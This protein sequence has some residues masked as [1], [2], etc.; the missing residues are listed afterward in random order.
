MFCVSHTV[1][2]MTQSG[3]GVPASPCRD[4]FLQTQPGPPLLLDTNPLSSKY[5]ANALSQSLA[6]LFTFFQ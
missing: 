1:R 6:F 5:V 3:P 4:V 2:L